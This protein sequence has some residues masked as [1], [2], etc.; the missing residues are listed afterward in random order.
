MEEI[1]KMSEEMPISYINQDPDFPWNWLK[2]STNPTLTINFVK[3]NLSKPWD[4]S[5]LNGITGNIDIED[6][7]E[8]LYLP[9]DLIGLFEENY[10]ELQDD[11]YTYFIKNICSLEREVINDLVIKFPNIC[12]SAEILS[13]NKCINIDTIK[14]YRDENWDWDILTR[15]FSLE[16]ILENKEL[17]WN[18]KIV[19][20]EKM[21]KLL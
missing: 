12:W 15:K 14:K 17:Y 18:W 20:L 19:C 7:E 3:Q 21:K 4:W 9:W 16:E 6:I 5:Y 2:V 1:N 13:H 8:N 11:S 10:I